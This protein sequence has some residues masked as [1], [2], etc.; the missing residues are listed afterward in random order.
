MNFILAL[1]FQIWLRAAEVFLGKKEGTL[2]KEDLEKLPM[3]EDV[4][5]MSSHYPHEQF[6]KFGPNHHV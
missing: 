3:G 6:L 5:P 1:I 2:S 4:D